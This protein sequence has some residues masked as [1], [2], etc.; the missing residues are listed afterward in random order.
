MRSAAI[1]FTAAAIFAVSL[2][3][4]V[5][6]L[7]AGVK[8]ETEV[9]YFTKDQAECDSCHVVTWQGTNGIMEDDKFCA[10]FVDVCV[11]CHEENLKRSHPVNV[12]A[13]KTLKKE[14]FPANLPVQYSEER[15]GDVLTCATCHKPH[16]ERLHDQKLHA[17]QK[18][19]P[20]SG[21]K[22]LSYFLR[23]RGANPREGYA[24]LCRS[25]HPNF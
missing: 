7:S 25:C 19:F 20:G 6:L 14:K 5:G 13:Y 15:R 23:V 21:G 2:F 18:E 16:A 24:P 11:M 4:G 8:E 10:S 12:F 9:H 1:L 22:Y 17:R 3:I